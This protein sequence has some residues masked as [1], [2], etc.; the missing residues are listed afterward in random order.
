MRAALLVWRP[1]PTRLAVTVAAKATFTVEGGIVA[2]ASEQPALTAEELV[3][4]KPRV[5]AMLVGSAIS[6]RVGEVS[7]HLQPGFDPEQTV[8]DDRMLA[9]P[10][11]NTI[12]LGKIAD[13]P[14]LG[15]LPL[16]MRVDRL[17][18]VHRRWA[19]QLCRARLDD[20]AMTI[21]EPAPLGFELSIFN[22][23]PDD[24]QLDQ[25][26]PGTRVI[27]EGLA[28]GR[29]LELRIPT[30]APIVTRGGRTLPMRLDTLTLDVDRQRLV[31]VWRALVDVQDIAREK[32][33]V[34]SNAPFSDLP[35]ETIDLAPAA[36]ERQLDTTQEV[37]ASSLRASVLPFGVASTEPLS[38]SAPEALPIARYAAASAGVEADPSRRDAILREADLTPASFVRLERRFLHAL[39]EARTQGSDDLER[40]IAAARASSTRASS[41]EMT[42]AD[43]AFVTVSVERGEIE[44]VL[45]AL[46]VELA[47]LMRIQQEWRRRLKADTELRA[48]VDQ[49]LTAERRT[50]LRPT[51]Q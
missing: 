26:L 2:L 31:L 14:R 10:Q 35:G 33:F 45:A 22:S 51:S 15:P 5:D 44:R 47:D 8:S 34:A 12:E 21:D 48:Q 39:E 36:S 50:R 25:L 17:D 6:F 23:A 7:K 16:I 41:T 30:R 43:Y 1:A 4:F 13:T 20:A 42:V 24:L 18:A 32:F 11:L 9:L 40:A 28:D 27:A 37:E 19:E 38:G 3:P 46:N 49:A 29:T